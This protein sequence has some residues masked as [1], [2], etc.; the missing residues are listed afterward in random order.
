M[1][2]KLKILGFDQGIPACSYVTQT[3]IVSNAE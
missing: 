3:E 2:D 1:Y